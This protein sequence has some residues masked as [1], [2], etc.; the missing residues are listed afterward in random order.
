MR[1]VSWAFE[2]L[3]YE[4]KFSSKMQLSFNSKF[5]CSL[6]AAAL[7]ITSH[8]SVILMVA[9]NGKQVLV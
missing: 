7:L 3:N 1:G 4:E 2:L 6:L 8:I 5:I 9:V